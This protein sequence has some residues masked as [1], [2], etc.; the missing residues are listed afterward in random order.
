[1]VG[2]RVMDNHHCCPKSYGC[3]SN[4]PTSNQDPFSTLDCAL[5]NAGTAEFVFMTL[6]GALQ[7]FFG[8]RVAGSHASAGFAHPLHRRR[9]VRPA[10]CPVLDW[11]VAALAVCRVTRVVGAFIAVVTK[12]C[13]VTRTV[14]E[15]ARVFGAF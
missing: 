15:V 12:T 7:Y 8:C 10:L 1:V 4:A 11:R 13:E 6:D 9:R 5:F 14:P 2:G 3:T